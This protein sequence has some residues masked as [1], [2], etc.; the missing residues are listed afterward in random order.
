MAEIGTHT[1]SPDRRPGGRDEVG[2]S[3]RVRDGIGH[4]GRATA[5]DSDESDVSGCVPTL[6]KLRLIADGDAVLWKLKSYADL[7]HFK[8][9]QIFR[10]VGVSAPQRFTEHHA[11]GGGF[12]SSRSGVW[13]QHKRRLPHEARTTEY[14]VPDGEIA[15]GL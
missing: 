14:H 5:C 15:D 2:P 9:A 6:G 10:E 11:I 1:D 3:D 4:G 12:G 8:A 13:T 7:R